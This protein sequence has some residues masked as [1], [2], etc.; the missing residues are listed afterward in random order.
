MRFIEEFRNQAIA[1]KWI[2]KIHQQVKSGRRYRLMEFCGGH[3]HV[4][5]R[6]GINNL[7]P[8]AID[9]IHGPGCP[10]CVLSIERID[11]AI[12]LANTPNVIL[13]TYA[14]MM[15]VP[16]TKQASLLKAK[17]KGAEVRMVYSVED[18]LQIARNN[19][20]KEVVF[21]AIGFET[22]TPATAVAIL[23]AKAEKLTNFT[24]FCNHVLTPVAMEALL[25][26]SQ[27]KAQLNGFIGPA[28]VSVIT[29][30]NAYQ[31]V[32]TQYQKPIVIAGF[33]PLD[34]LQAISWLV[35]MIDQGEVGVK[36][37]YIRAVTEKGNLKA[38]DLIDEVLCLRA[39]FEWRG[40]GH[41]PNSGL[42]LKSQ[43]QQFDAEHRFDI[44]VSKSAEHKACRCADILC[45]EIKPKDCA[46][47]GLACTPENPLGACMVSSEGACAASY[48]YETSSIT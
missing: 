35:A 22:T 46:L 20:Q 10:V 2:N 32:A 40:L 31:S 23:R 26:H 17:A 4:I 6:Y 43:Y 28:H 15:R 21:F 42:A 11:K 47:F 7:L 34:M 1:K 12:A 37:Q 13:C 19:I 8:D 45:G 3:T 30:S 44:Q 39:Q 29:G 24:V 16:G 48:A 33:E 38:Q 5:H 36:N 14:D 18:A 41:I 9:M 27:D 25:V